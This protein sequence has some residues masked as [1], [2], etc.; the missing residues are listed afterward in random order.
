MLVTFLTLFSALAFSQDKPR[1]IRGIVQETKGGIYVGGVLIE[2][3]V[4]PPEIKIDQIV[5]KT[6][7]VKG[8]VETAPKIEIPPGP[9]VQYREGPYEYFK[10]IE[11]LKILPAPSPIIK[12][13]HSAKPSNLNRKKHF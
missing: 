6:I 3:G 13:G 8:Y 1:I 11:S 4:L 10:K 12:E 7:E 9:A 2:D 5:G